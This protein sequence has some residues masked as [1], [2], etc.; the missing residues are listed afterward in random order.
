MA[1]NYGRRVGGGAGEDLQ[2]ARIRSTS[3]SAL[4]E[5]FAT[6]RWMQMRTTSASRRL[7]LI[8]ITRAYAYDRGRIRI[9]ACSC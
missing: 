7:K 1:S 5:R 2:Q 9:G 4:G 8:M 6:G 3:Y